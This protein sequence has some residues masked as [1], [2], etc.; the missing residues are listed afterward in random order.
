VDIKSPAIAR[1]LVVLML[2]DELS[3]LAHDA[4]KAKSSKI[5]MCLFYTYLSAIMPSTLLEV[6]Q[7]RIGEARNALEKN[8]LPPFIEIPDMYRAEIIGY[9]DD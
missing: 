8:T 1:D 4:A 5:L 7:V 9:L 2:L 6:L 3:E